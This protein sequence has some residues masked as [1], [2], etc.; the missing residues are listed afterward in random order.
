M[1]S[2]P[3][4]RHQCNQF[5]VGQGRGKFAAEDAQECFRGLLE[6]IFVL[7]KQHGQESFHCEGLALTITMYQLPLPF[8]FTITVHGQCVVVRSVCTS[9]SETLKPRKCTVEVSLVKTCVGSNLCFPSSCL[10]RPAGSHHDE[11][12]PSCMSLMTNSFWERFSML[13]KLL[14]EARCTV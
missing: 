3:G 5:W 6:G 14:S 8:P 2:S 1:L 7:L 12:R 13:P 9:H 10:V 4:G 11:T